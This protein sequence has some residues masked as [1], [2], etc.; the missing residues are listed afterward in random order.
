MTTTFPDLMARGVPPVGTFLSTPALPFLEIAKLSGMDFVVIDNEHVLMSGGDLDAMLVVARGLELPALVRIPDHGYADV[1]RIL[2][3]GAA[4][5]FVPH[6]PTPAM[7]SQVVRQMIHP[8]HG[9]RGAHGG[10][11]AGGWGLDEVARSRYT[12][13][14]YIY[15]V[16]MIED[17]SAVEQI[18]EILATPYL[19]A[20]YVGPGDLSLSMGVPAS[21]PS[22][23]E[24]IVRVRDRAKAAG[25]HVGALA[26]DAAGMKRLQDEGYDWLVANND[27]GLFARA[28]RDILSEV[29]KK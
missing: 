7:A 20:V 25:V 2:D 3:A 8:P 28:C 12:D 26:G 23:Q 15:R 4:G 6:V 21:D 9:T 17:R 22:V 18:D 5:I 14:A 11:R 27:I 24:A 13:P 1:Q 19:S 16:A 10:M 29:R